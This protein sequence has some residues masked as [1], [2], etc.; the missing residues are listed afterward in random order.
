MERI[1][2]IN[3]RKRKR[4][5]NSRLIILGIAAAIIIIFGSWLIMHRTVV[6]SGV[7]T[8]R[9]DLPF[10]STEKFLSNSK[11]IAYQKGNSIKGIDS[12]AKELF[13]IDNVSDE[14]K[15]YLS[16]KNVAYFVKN[17]YYVYDLTGKEISR[18]ETEDTIYD[19]RLA[20]EYVAFVKADAS[21]NTFLNLNDFKQGQ[22][23]SIPID[24]NNLL[25]FGVIS[26]SA[27]VWT[28]VIDTSIQTP[29]CIFTAYSSSKNSRT[30]VINIAEQLLEKIIV[31]S[32]KVY[33]IGTSNLV[34]YDI[35]GK[36]EQTYLTYGWKVTDSMFVGA[37][38]YFVLIP[39]T[40]GAITSV[41]IR[42]SDSSEYTFTLQEEC[43]KVIIGN[44]R[45]Y[46]FNENRVFYT[47]LKGENI[48]K[49]DTPFK[50]RDVYSVFDG[51][52]VIADNGNSFTLLS[53]K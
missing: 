26:S 51:T 33:A 17:S 50:I 5:K 10:Y 42:H 44:E 13:S 46:A 32:D 27:T 41:R 53:L 28:S 18:Y 25:D 7:F 38:P 16:E 11:V 49:T 39:R 19:I 15:M 34:T 48:K 4:A 29:L 20:D 40:D 30:S 2:A 36:K 9:T 52:Y 1:K 37:K 24:T 45:I 6:S 8:T 22:L 23:F 43:N 12:K 35:T 14:A 3:K 21:G 47:D 31:N